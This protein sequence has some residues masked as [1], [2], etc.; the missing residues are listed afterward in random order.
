MPPE[1][2]PLLEII[3]IFNSQKGNLAEKHDEAQ[4]ALIKAENI[5][6]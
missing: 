4:I 5:R 2:N 3:G 6:E 1:E